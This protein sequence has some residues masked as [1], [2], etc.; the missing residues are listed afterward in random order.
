MYIMSCIYASYSARS[1]R[2]AWR[3]RTES[4]STAKGA[5][6]ANSWRRTAAVKRVTDSLIRCMLCN[7]EGKDDGSVECLLLL[8]FFLFSECAVVLSFQVDLPF[9]RFFEKKCLSVFASQFY[10]FAV[11]L[12][13]IDVQLPLHLSKS[14]SWQLFAGHREVAGSH[15]RE[16]LELETGEFEKGPGDGQWKDGR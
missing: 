1:L 7:K 6:C 12:P 2:E 13:S 14:F 4:C 3:Q 8:Y 5:F 11:T 10:Q 16:A 9:F 15:R